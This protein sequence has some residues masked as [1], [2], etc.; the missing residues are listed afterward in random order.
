MRDLITTRRMAE[1][2]YIVGRDDFEAVV[3]LPVNATQACAALV[4]L[5]LAAD[6]VPD[7]QAL[8]ISPSTSVAQVNEGTCFFWQPEC[9]MGMDVTPESRYVSPPMLILDNVRSSDNIGVIL[10]TAFSLGLRSLIVTPTSLS[11]VGCRAARTSMGALSYFSIFLANDLP[12]TIRTLRDLGIDVFA[13]SPDGRQ[14]VHSVRS[15]RWALVVGNEE[16][17]SRPETFAACTKTLVIPQIS[18]DSLSVSVATGIC[19][20]ELQREKLS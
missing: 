8:D 1:G 7:V 11:A 4:N 13:T 19:L 5:N 6:I 16:K 9:R 18:G 10:R 3:G 17:G 20:Y 15:R 14:A 2:I 12:S